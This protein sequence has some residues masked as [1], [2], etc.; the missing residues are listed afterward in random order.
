M[1]GLIIDLFAG[2]GGAST[3]LEAAL[4]RPVDIAIN[5]DPIALDVHRANHPGT[6]HVEEDIW[7]ANPA[8][9]VRGRPVAILW[10][11]PDCA[12]HSNAKGGKPRSN[13]IRT[14]AWAVT[15]WAKAVR[16]AVIFLENVIEFKSWG[17]LTIQGK[18]DKRFLGKTFNAW[19][20]RLERLGYVVDFRT[21]DSSRYG[22]PTKR[23]R[24]FMIARCDGQP[25][26]W[27]LESHGPNG[28]PVRTAAE[29]IDWSLPCPSIFERPYP[30]AEKTLW[31]I[32]Q[33]LNRFVFLN[34]EPYIVGVGGR[35]RQSA[36]T[37]ASAP[38][39]TI[40]AKNDRALV[41]P[42]LV[43]T[44][45]GV[46][47]KTGRREHSLGEPLGAVMAGGNGRSL[48]APTLVQTGYGERDGQ[49]ARVLDIREPLGTVVAG[50]A[51]HALVAAFLAKH[52]GDRGQRPGSGLNEPVSTIT[53]NDHNALTAATLVKLRGECH[54]AELKLPLPVITAGGF[55]YGEVRAF[56]TAYHASDYAGGFGQSLTDP[57]RT[58][59]TTDRM[60]LVTIHG[61]EYAIVDIGMRML[62]PF[63]LLRAQF[64]RFAAGY[65]LSR[66]VGKKGK[67]THKVMVRLIGNSVSPE[68]AEAIVAAN[69]HQRETRKVA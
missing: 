4:G 37:P 34:P 7:K 56:L 21:L 69:H 58:V 8:E 62:N 42:Y 1:N 48:I 26:S 29:I 11:S 57:L 63:E 54:G 44:N 13:K 55:H 66:A 53:A 2:A 5:H 32:A 18:P 50:G 12:H 39:G 17:P 41:T 46:D 27:P 60:G 64:G 38:L 9:L 3:G 25:I 33:G 23:R 14:L 16:P 35:A 24:L 20:R 65:D 31:R 49:A 6:L 68:T 40:T 15:R 43:E 19:T 52:Y 10:A 61:H 22:A 28:K 30:L 47:H 36:P 67:P 51:K 59:T 45:H